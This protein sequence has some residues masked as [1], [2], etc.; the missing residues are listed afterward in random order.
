MRIEVLHSICIFI[1][2]IKRIKI[3]LTQQPNRVLIHKPPG[4]RLVIAH[5]VVMQSRL[6]VGV[7]VL[8]PEGLVCDICYL[9]FD[10]QTIPSRY[11]CRTT[12]G[13]RLYRSSL[14][15][16]R[17]GRSGSSGFLVGFRRLR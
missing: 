16:S 6:T 5:Q 13:C 4:L 12:S 15:G 10:F 9:G 7:L 2:F 11:S 3:L 8:K 14:F 17:F 1:K